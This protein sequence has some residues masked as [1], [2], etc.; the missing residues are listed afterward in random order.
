MTSR[1]KL[2]QKALDDPGSLRFEEA[3]RLAAAHG[4]SLA[5]SRGS[6]FI[7]RHTRFSGLV[8]PPKVGAMAKAYQVRQ[9]LN[10]LRELGLVEEE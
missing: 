9:L 4:F 5:R 2:L 1:A 6:H 3:C 8:N 10:A 7:Y